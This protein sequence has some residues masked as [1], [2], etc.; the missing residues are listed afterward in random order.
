MPV[1]A[2]RADKDGNSEF[3]I[4]KEYKKALDFNVKGLVVAGAIKVE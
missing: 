3:A 2:Q 4:V 1:Q